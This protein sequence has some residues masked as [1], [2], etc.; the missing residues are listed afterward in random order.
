MSNRAIQ[1]SNFTL[2][3]I[4]KL[5]KIQVSNQ[6]SL[7]LNNQNRAVVK[8]SFEIIR[9]LLLYSFVNYYGKP[10]S[11]NGQLFGIERI[12]NTINEKIYNLQQKKL[13]GITTEDLL[14][15]V[16]NSSKFFKVALTNNFK[17]FLKGIN[18]YDFIDF[19]FDTQIKNYLQ[20]NMK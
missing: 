20:K 2:N 15:F 8:E 10:T 6:L 5:D 14:K 18:E 17:E 1:Y 12:V 11:Y 19:K 4:K 16:S 3:E 13:T 7:L 9:F